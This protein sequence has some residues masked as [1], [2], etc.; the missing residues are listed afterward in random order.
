MERLEHAR[1]IQGALAAV[2][3]AVVG[4]IAN[5]PAW[6]GLHVLFAR[7]APPPPWLPHLSLP[8]LASVDWAALGLSLV[9]AVLLFRL[10][11]GV[12]RTLGVCVVLGL[13]LF[14]LGLR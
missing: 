5:L 3:A 13:A 11:F 4:V 12:I 7:F 14:A 10:H 9:A 2:T 1:R 8:E 6:F